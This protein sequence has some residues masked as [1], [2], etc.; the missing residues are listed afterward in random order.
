MF[1]VSSGNVQLFNFAPC[2]TP[3]GMIVFLQDN[4]RNASYNLPVHQLLDNFIGSR[5]IMIIK[6]KVLS[7]ATP[8]SFF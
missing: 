8:N 7:I 5:Y 3:S 1:K 2:Y 6:A 4:W